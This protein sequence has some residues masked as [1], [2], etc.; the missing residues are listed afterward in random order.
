MIARL[1]TLIAVLGLAAAAHAGTDLP[2]TAGLAPPAGVLGLRADA[3][4]VLLA[5]SVEVPPGRALA[6]IAWYSRTVPTSVTCGVLSSLD[7]DPATETDRTLFQVET[8]RDEAPGWIRA[9]FPRPLV[10]G[11]R[12]LHVL[13]LMD[14]AAQ[15]EMAT[16]DRPGVGFTADGSGCRA[17]ASSDGRTWVAFDRAH[18]LA[19]AP[20]LVEADGTGLLLSG[21]GGGTLAAAAAVPLRTGFVAATPNPFNPEITLSYTLARGNPVRIAVHDLRGRRVA[22]LVDGIEPAGLHSVGWRGRDESG[23]RLPSGLF[24]ARLEAEGIVDI[25]R[26]TMI[27]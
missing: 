27:R 4:S 10:P 17:W 22:L 16:E 14:L 5:A 26:I 20:L 19:L 7:G 12:P 21:D 11:D 2:P 1:F 15:D 18:G 25:I 13:L 24:L 9:R 8:S 3:P 23:N 6:G